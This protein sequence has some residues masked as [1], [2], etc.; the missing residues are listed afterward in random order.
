MSIDDL[1]K[2]LA[3]TNQFVIDEA[4]SMFRKD[5][6]DGAINIGQTYSSIAFYG[7]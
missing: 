3:E 1:L 4:P 6:P 7:G 5:I 2:A